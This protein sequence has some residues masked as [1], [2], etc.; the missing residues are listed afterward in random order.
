MSTND[1]SDELDTYAEIP[2][3]DNI[4][5]VCIYETEM[6]EY[7]RLRSQVLTPT[8]DIDNIL[9]D[10]CDVEIDIHIRSYENE[11]IQKEILKN[12]PFAVSLLFSDVSRHFDTD[13]SEPVDISK[14]QLFSITHRITESKFYELNILLIDLRI[15]KFTQ[16]H[17]II[18]AY[19]DCCI[20]INDTILVNYVLA[21][22]R[23]IYSKQF[24]NACKNIYKNIILPKDLCKWLSKYEDVPSDALEYISDSI[25]GIS[26]MV[27][28]LINH[29]MHDTVLCTTLC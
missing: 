9:D 8:S 10:D 24:N 28:V 23:V 5:N 25:N 17:D 11:Y 4:D 15:W 18:M 29:F 13:F 16:K 26:R 21:I 3:F 20:A 27:F 19:L 6:N 22:Y 2:D 1:S 12:I 7:F 14:F